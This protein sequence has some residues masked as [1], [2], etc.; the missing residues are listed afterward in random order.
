M[1]VI[2]IKWSVMTTDNPHM[3]P[4]SVD[5]LGGSCLL[6]YHCNL[7]HIQMYLEENRTLS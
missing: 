2:I 4:G 5:L 3:Q 7:K 6:M 1:V